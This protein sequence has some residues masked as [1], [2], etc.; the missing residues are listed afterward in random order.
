MKTGTPISLKPVAVALAVLLAGSSFALPVVAADRT[1]TEAAGVA[2]YQGWGD[3][4]M[5]EIAVNSGQ[6]L[7]NHLMT[8]RALLDEGEVV[9][10]RSALIASREFADAIERMMPYLTV[11]EELLDA[12]DR[13]IQEKVDTLSDD[14]LPI[15]A[16]IDE[17]TV[18]APRVAGKT[19]GMLQQAENH[20][21]SG[22][23][24]HAAS[25]LRAAASEVSQHTVYLP[26]GY[27]QR[28]IRVAQDA[29]NREKPDLSTAKAAVENSLNSLNL[30]V[31]TVIQTAAR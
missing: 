25:M 13:V 20:A 9:Q 3:P 30:V 4:A 21:R 7:I 29:L 8:T 28:Q 19:R 1:Q 26:V 14:L 17:M 11:V 12:S 23:A 24:R 18:Y 6:A 16:G 5:A 10:A 31:D 15:Y 2:R 27:V 22:D